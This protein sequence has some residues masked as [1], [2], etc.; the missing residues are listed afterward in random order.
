MKD[1]IDQ[2]EKQVELIDEYYLKIAERPPVEFKNGDSPK[3]LLAR[4]RYILANNVDQWTLNQ[5]K[6][7][8]ILV[9][10]YSQLETAYHQVLTFRN[11]YQETNI[12]NTKLKFEAW[13]K[14][15]QD[16]EMKAFYTVANTENNILDNIINFIKNRTANAESCKLNVA[17]L[18]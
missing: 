1:F 9:K 10:I 3:Q 8:E 13:N 6:R 12:A 5:K 14:N 11:I 17:P 4:S 7:A 15:V 16:N 2:P 18:K